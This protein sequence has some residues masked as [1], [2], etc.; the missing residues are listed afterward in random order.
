MILA[1][2]GF[3]EGY[4]DEWRRGVD[5]MLSVSSN[6]EA[7][8]D[9]QTADLMSSEG[10]FGSSLFRM[11][12]DLIEERRRDPKDDLMSVLVAS[13]LDEDGSI[14]K[15]TDEE[16]FSFVLLISAAGTETVARLLG[17]AGSLFDQFPDQRAALVDDPSLIPNAVE[18]CLRYEAPSPV[19][20]RW[21]NA[22]VEFQ[23][24]L[25]P[26]GS[27]L[28]MLNG[29]A[30]R[31]ER[32]FPDADTF[33]VR[34]TID[35]HLSFGYGAHFCVGAALAHRG[36]HRDPRDAQ[37]LPDV[38]GR[39][40]RRRDDPDL[41]RPRLHEAPGPRLTT[42]L[43]RRGRSDR[44]LRIEE[45]LQHGPDHRRTP[46][47]DRRLHRSDDGRRS[48]PGSEDRARGPRTSAEAWFEDIARRREEPAHGRAADARE[49]GGTPALPAGVDATEV[50]IPVEGSC[51]SSAS[52]DAC[53]RGAITAFVYRPT[54]V[55][56]APAYLTLHG[57]GWWLM[58]GDILRNSGQ[59]HAAMALGPRDRRRRRQLPPH[60]GAQVPA[61]RGR[62]LCGADLGRRTCRRARRRP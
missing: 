58:G 56:A 48:L 45:R 11:L 33:D 32:H 1:L 43:S 28:L 27:K 5:S 6:G 30:N 31:D 50:T 41:D 59:S 49:R 46:P 23:G 7:R 51:G 18:E 15:L 61:P 55:T 14:R 39:P 21:V 24:Q 47:R 52:C 62:L 26:K 57:G 17:W 12:P 60:S 13:D 2:V 53:A 10:A 40:W 25:V 22:D 4:E 54:G 3:P 44:T 19:N 8:T 34:R 42:P 36:T 35:R 29:S 38:G 16:I 20:G 37:A 9:E